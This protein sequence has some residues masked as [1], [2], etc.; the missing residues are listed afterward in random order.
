[1]P[2]V[3]CLGVSVKFTLFSGDCSLVM[4]SNILKE[5]AVSSVIDVYCGVEV[6]GRTFP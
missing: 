2:V 4:Y 6:G 5:P 3:C 1:M